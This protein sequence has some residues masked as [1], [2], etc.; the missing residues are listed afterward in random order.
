MSTLQTSTTKKMKNTLYPIGYALSGGF[1]KG[2]AHLG[3]MQALRE[4]D[5]HPNI[6][7][8]VSAG[9]LAGAFYADGTEPYDALQYFSGYK[10]TDLTR[11]TIPKNGFFDLTEFIDFVRSHI[12]AKNIEDLK[13]PLIV[14]ATNLDNG[15]LT[16]FKSGSLPERVA[17]SCCMP[18]MFSPVQIE[19]VSYVD[20]GIFMNFPPSTIRPICEKVIGINVSPLVAKD[21]KNNLLH[22]AF[23]S[24]NFMFKANAFPQ[25]RLCDILIEPNELDNF[26]MT[27]LE[28]AEEIFK[29]GYK[30]AKEQIEKLKQ[31]SKDSVK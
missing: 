20:G 30:S 24:F 8:G 7:S 26:G 11:W 16:H 5:I 28:Q 10:F 6:I 15:T 13:I 12:K 14:T 4:A 25:R 29:V 2:F 21:Y 3:A 18:I 1:I 9:A 31:I 19:G 22:I 27:D 23:R 17:A